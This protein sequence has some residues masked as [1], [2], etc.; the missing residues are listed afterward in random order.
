[1]KKTPENCSYNL[2]HEPKVLEYKPG[3]EESLA[4][5]TAV[6]LVVIQEDKPIRIC[7]YGSDDPKNWNGDVCD[8][9]STAASCPYFSSIHNE[10]DKNKEFDLILNDDKQTLD[11]YPDVAALQWVLDVRHP[12]PKLGLWISMWLWLKTLFA[13]LIK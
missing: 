5:R 9:E 3:I 2:L 11:L 8:H 4:P 7:T 1:M 13:R 10:N 6:S 12:L